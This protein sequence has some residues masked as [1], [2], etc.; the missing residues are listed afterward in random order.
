MLGRV[1]FLAI[2]ALS[3]ALPAQALRRVY[4]TNIDAASVTVLDAER[5][6]VLS[7]IPVGREPDGVAVSPDGTSVWVAN[8][9]DDSVSMIDTATDSVVDTIAVGDGPVGLA[10]TPD[11][12]EVWV[13]NRLSGTVSI[14]DSATRTLD[15]EI[16]LGAAS[17]VNAIAFTPDGARALVTQSLRDT[18][19]VIDSAQRRVADGVRIGRVPNRVVVAPDGGR[20]YVSL[21]RGDNGSELSSQL[22]AID[23]AT[24]EVVGRANASQPSGLALSTDARTVYLADI[25]EVQRYDADSLT[26]LGTL[27]VGNGLNGILPLDERTLLVADTPRS[28]LRVLP[29]TFYFA[30]SGL[31]PLPPPVPVA[32]GP[33]ALAALPQREP[34]RLLAAITAPSFGTK[35]DRSASAEVRIVAAAGELPLAA[36]NI[37]LRR[38]DG[39][40][41][42]QVLASGSA[43]VADAVVATLRGADLVAGAAYGLVLTVLAPD[44][45]SVVRHLPFSVPNR[46]YALVPLRASRGDYESRLEMDAEARQFIAGVGSYS[47]DIYNTD[48]GNTYDVG[49]RLELTDT[50]R[51]VMSRGGRRVGLIAAG[52]LGGTFDLNSGQFWLVP[53]RPYLYDIDADGEWLA[54]LRIETIGQRYQLFDLVG[55]ARYFISDVPGDDGG[56]AGCESDEGQRPRISA[57]GGRVAFLT[58]F[59]LGLGASQGCRLVAYERDSQ[60]LRLVAELTGH[61]I[62]LPSMD[63]AGAQFG[64]V[65]GPAVAHTDS[66]R[67]ATL[68]DLTSGAR[69]DLLGDNPAQSFDAALSGD[70]RSV[71]VSSCADLDPSVGNAD[72]NDELFRLDLASGSFAQITDTQGGETKCELT[73]GAAYDPLVSRDGQQLSFVMLDASAAGAPR[74]LRNGFAFGAVRAVPIVDGNTPPKFELVGET[75]VLVGERLGLT[76]RSGDRD[77]DP[78][79]FF[80][81]MGEKGLPDDVSFRLD[82]NDPQAFLQWY[83]PA[84]AAGEHTLRLGVFDDRGGE[85]V[86]DVILSVCRLYVD[87][88]SRE[89]VAAAIFG[90]LPAACGDADSNGD[91]ALNAADLLVS[92]APG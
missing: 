38:T 41:P 18:L 36:W 23:L 71:I 90:A 42:D 12:A 69:R 22:V 78:L 72:R 17:G 47:I 52:R 58:G 92:G 63:D 24:L 54:S 53:Y 37:I 62:G 25:A 31:P 56:G 4:V 61:S 46:R 83:P 50:D 44:S 68:I 88:S 21:F 67:R 39:T 91:G 33:Y 74:S 75:T 45:S 66:G 82:L 40:A 81:Q 64:V 60:S 84:D 73:R 49:T 35:L 51:V 7:V 59:D 11:G 16:A 87:A 13:T 34:D 10:V 2:G 27:S 79:R 55:G 65:L 43:P 86:R 85:V 8:F 30:D 14:L 26:L 28:L 3:V 5:R 6:T 9:A 77:F 89:L 32:V 29:A 57:D 48:T 1:A 76:L 80:A 19:S 15:G 20:A 70:G